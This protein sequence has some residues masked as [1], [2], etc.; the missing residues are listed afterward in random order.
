MLAPP[1]AALATLL[2]APLPSRART[3]NAASADNNGFEY[4]PALSDKDYG[5]V[6]RPQRAQR[7]RYPRGL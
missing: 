1:L 3:S 2:S 6:R 4:M 5:K 7:A